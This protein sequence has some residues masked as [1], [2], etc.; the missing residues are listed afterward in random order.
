MRRCVMRLVL[1]SALCAAAVAQQAVISDVLAGKLV[2]PKVGQWAWYDLTDA[3]SGRRFMLRQAIVGKEKVGR[4][5]GY[6]VEF[7][8]IPDVGYKAVYNMLLTGPASDPKHV[9]RLIVREG[10]TAPEELPKPDEPNDAPEPPKVKRKSLGSELVETPAGVIEAEHLTLTT[11]DDVSEV[12]VNDE[13]RPM[14]IVQMR[15]KDGA[16]V[17]RGFGEGGENA[18]AV[19]NDEPQRAEGRALPRPKI[20]VRVGDETQVWPP[21][22]AQSEDVPDAVSE[23]AEA[24]AKE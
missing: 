15:S 11:A 6:W 18:R 8:I 21:P 20:E 1:C 4:K 17:L 14:G 2:K 13:I 16:L 7:E 19:M 24:P 5:T 12:W 9:H 23:Q 3:G 22:D 10:L